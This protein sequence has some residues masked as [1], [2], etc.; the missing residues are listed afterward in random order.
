MNEEPMR[1]S[2]D[3]KRPPAV[4]EA[5]RSMRGEGPSDDSRRA[6]LAA[7]GVAPSAAAPP[8]VAPRARPLFLRWTLGGLALGALALGA[9]RLLGL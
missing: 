5:L 6:A 8:P 2:D 7:L 4:R 9:M 1:Y 3:D